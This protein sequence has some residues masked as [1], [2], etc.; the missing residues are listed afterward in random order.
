MINLLRL[1]GILLISTNINTVESTTCGNSPMNTYYM[2]NELG[3][4]TIKDCDIINSSLIIQGDYSINSL[5]LLSNLKQITGYL[6]ILDSHV[7]N[8]LNGLQ[9]LKEINGDN[10]YLQQYS[11]VIK[12]NNNNIN[13]YNNGLCYYSNVN[14]NDIIIK[15]YQL[16][17]DNNDICPQCDSNCDGCFGPGPQLCQNCVNYQSSNT[18]VNEC[19]NNSIEYTNNKTCLEKIPDIP[20]LHLIALSYDTIYLNWSKPINSRGYINKYEL[21]NDEQLIYDTSYNL[22]SYNLNNLEFNYTYQNLQSYKTYNFSIYA[23]NS[24]GRNVYNRYVAKTLEGLPTS[25]N[26]LVY[27]VIN[28]SFVE[29]YFNNP[30]SINGNLVKFEYSINETLESVNYVQ[31]N[32][33]FNNNN[34]NNKINLNNLESYT[35]YGFKIRAY[36]NS[37]YGDWSNNSNFITSQSIPSKP[38]NPHYTSISHNSVDIKW[39][40][41][42][43]KN[44]VMTNYKYKLERN[45]ILIAE[46]ILNNLNKE[47]SKNNLLPYTNYNFS[48]SGV[49]GNNVYSE[50]SDIL[51]FTTNQ[52]YPDKI[53]NIN[54][55]VINQSM[56]IIY[57]SKPPVTNGVLTQ[58]EIKLTKPDS[59]FNKY[60][61]DINSLQS[62]TEPGYNYNFGVNGLD[63]YTLYKYNIRSY[64]IAGPGSYS[65]DMYFK[66]FISDP[67]L[68]DIPIINLDSITL[69]SLTITF[70]NVSNINGEIESY[71]LIVDNINTSITNNLLILT[72]NVINVTNLTNNTRYR[73]ALIACTSN[74]LCSTSSYTDIVT[75]LNKDSNIPNNHNN[76]INNDSSKKNNNK[77]YE[78][79]GIICGSVAFV[80]LI[81]FI[82]YKKKQYNERQ[83]KER[84][85]RLEGRIIDRTNREVIPPVSFKNPTYNIIDNTGTGNKSTGNT[86]TCNTVSDFDQYYDSDSDTTVDT[87]YNTDNISTPIR[88]IANETYNDPITSFT[89]EI[90]TGGIIAVTPA[91]AVNNDLDIKSVDSSDAI[92]NDNDS[93][94]ESNS[95]IYSKVSNTQNNKLGLD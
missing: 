47:V 49:N 32:Y 73:F 91:T 50:Y 88:T 54:S 2:N 24:A 83:N 63:S 20:N 4:S 36:T 28:N 67:P 68:P 33:V 15:G 23:Y 71:Y 93:G 82:L 1:L 94:S 87:P 74:I 90:Y 55:S 34:Y 11:L 85:S 8:N 60:S 29:V 44:G 18:C 61:I 37:G 92:D 75:T 10:L 14:W 79:I 76:D 56:A 72:N 59:Q 69:D 77:T 53:I 6:V 89:N 66:T 58:Y 45:G 25:P 5:E 84:L 48:V 22:N 80:I 78:L 27:N 38:I 19:F 64:T 9:N 7:L 41:P 26:N 57:F 13:D 21:Y 39:D 43:N 65:N 12:H 81:L 42:I 16:I 70:S 35:N 46:E 62:S 51:S 95:Y 86:G 3:L 40:D 52:W 17:I 30:T 31:S